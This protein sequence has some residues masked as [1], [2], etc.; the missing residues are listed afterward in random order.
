MTPDELSI[1]DAFQEG[2]RAGMLALS[3]SLNPYQ[4]DTPEHAEWE[5]ARLAALAYRLARAA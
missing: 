1:Q 3:P 4:D 5:R 2:Q